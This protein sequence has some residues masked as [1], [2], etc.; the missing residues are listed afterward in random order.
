M[1]NTCYHCVQN[2]TYVHKG[3][4]LYSLNRKKQKLCCIYKTNGMNSVK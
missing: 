1:E 3:L 2:Q 4:N